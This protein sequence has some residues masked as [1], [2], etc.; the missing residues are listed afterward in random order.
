MSGTAAFDDVRELYQNIILE[1]GRHPHHM[2]RMEPCD[3]HAFGE[4]P[5]CGD[6]VEVRVR[7]TPGGTVAEA[8]F[9]A[10]GCAISMASADLMADVVAGRDAAGIRTLAEEFAELA[11]TGS[12]ASSDPA[13]PTLQ[14]LSG[15][16]EYR[17][18]VKC[19]TLPWSALIAALDSAPGNAPASDPEER[20]Q[21]AQGDRP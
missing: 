8:A 7:F 9:E 18:R 1:R 11:R 10:R 17:S 14:P 15:V 12:T 2:H 20:P 21:R 16:S 3:A 4:N 13:I 6:Q 19:A 5:L